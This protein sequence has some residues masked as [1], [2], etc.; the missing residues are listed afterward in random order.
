MSG[1]F[2]TI[3]HA[4]RG[5]IAVLMDDDGAVQTGIGAYPTPHGALK[6]ARAWAAEEGLPVEDGAPVAV[7]TAER[8]YTGIG[9]RETPR[10]MLDLMTQIARRLA[11]DGWGLRS[12]GAPG[13]D[14]AFERGAGQGR[15]EIWL[16]WDGFNSRK[17]DGRSYRLTSRLPMA[18]R[19]EQLAEAHHPAWPRLSQA[20][21]RLM[22]RNATQVLGEDLATPSRFVICWAPSPRIDEQGRVVDVKG[23]TGLAVRLAATHG[24]PVFHLGVAEHRDRIERFLAHVPS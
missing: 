8:W 1:A 5:W 24:V 16:P 21:R 20:A 23:G 12:G 10:D 13:A 11:A 14:D 19:A 18:Q 22:T 17:V 9:S 6:E 2:I 15:R 4:M 7:P 3:Q